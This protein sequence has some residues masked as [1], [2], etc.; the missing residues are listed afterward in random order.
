MQTRQLDAI[1]AEYVGAKHE[2]M[3]R[4]VKAIAQNPWATELDFDTSMLRLLVRRHGAKDAQVVI[5]Y[6]DGRGGGRPRDLSL[7]KFDVG[8]SGPPLERLEG[9]S[10]EDAIRRLENWLHPA[11]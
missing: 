2:P 9:L 10:M 7:N 11:S 4:L 5:M 8:V 1:I 3:V 6:G